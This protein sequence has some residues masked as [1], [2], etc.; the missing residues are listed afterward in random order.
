MVVFIIS[1]SISFKN[2]TK[3]KKGGTFLTL[4]QPFTAPT[5]I[6]FTKYFW[7]NGKNSII[8]PI[9]ITNIAIRKFSPGKS[10]GFTETGIFC[11]VFK[12]D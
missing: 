8:G 7:K 2:A 4:H 6:P 11:M 3:S 9:A 10:D 5:V 1:K 12:I